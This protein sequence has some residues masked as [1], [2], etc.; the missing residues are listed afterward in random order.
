MKSILRI[1]FGILFGIC[2]LF[3]VFYFRSKIS[4][5]MLCIII[6]WATS[7][8]MSWSFFFGLREGKLSAKGSV[9]EREKNPF[10]FWFYVFFYSFIIIFC[11]LMG[12][13]SLLK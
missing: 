10:G 3:G 8:A 9:Y 12:A 7:L 2:A 13:W 1:I 5:K 6:P 11:I 4:P